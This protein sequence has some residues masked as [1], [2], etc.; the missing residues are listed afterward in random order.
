MN[1]IRYKTLYIEEDK[2]CFTNNLKLKQNT[3]LK[4]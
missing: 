2:W 4:R 3:K 1:P